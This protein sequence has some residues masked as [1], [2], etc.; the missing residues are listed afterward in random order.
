MAAPE[1][2][3]E[4]IKPAFHPGRYSFVD[5]NAESGL[6]ESTKLGFNIGLARMFSGLRAVLR[7]IC[8]VPP[9]VKEP[10]EAE[11]EMLQRHGSFVLVCTRAIVQLCMA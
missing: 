7:F 9:N 5:T 11:T 4:Y 1:P 10:S 8:M 2:A 6:I 3:H